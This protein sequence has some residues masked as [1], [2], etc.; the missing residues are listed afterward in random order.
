MEFMLE[1]IQVEVLTGLLER[2][3]ESMGVDESTWK[4][5]RWRGFWDLKNSGCRE[6]RRGTQGQILRR[7]SQDHRLKQWFLIKPEGL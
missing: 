1:E 5:N 4:E 6:R 3:L 7:K 2:V